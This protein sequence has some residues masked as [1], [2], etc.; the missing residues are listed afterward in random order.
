MK[1]GGGGEGGEKVQKKGLALL[2]H[3][4]TGSPGIKF[5]FP[6]CD[7]STLKTIFDIYFTPVWYFLA[8]KNVFKLALP[9]QSH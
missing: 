2:F 5:A 6:T 3:F 8:T 9:R 1:G 4:A 7:W